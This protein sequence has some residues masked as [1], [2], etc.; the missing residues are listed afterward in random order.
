MMGDSKGQLTYPGLGRQLDLVREAGAVL[1]LQWDSVAIRTVFYGNASKSVLWP[2][3]EKGLNYLFISKKC[4]GELKKKL[5]LELRNYIN[6]FVHTKN[7]YF[8]MCLHSTD[9]QK[10]FLLTLRRIIRIHKDPE[11]PA[12][13]LAACF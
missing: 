3:V 2:C 12:G 5:I 11:C 9:T 13:L 4:D 8:S 7:A 1:K 6:L 10:N